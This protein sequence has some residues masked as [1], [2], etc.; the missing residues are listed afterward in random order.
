MVHAGVV[1]SSVLVGWRCG[2]CTQA[3][4]DAYFRRA[5][6]SQREHRHQNHRC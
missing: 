4:D 6:R 3:A 2:M 1:M 5:N